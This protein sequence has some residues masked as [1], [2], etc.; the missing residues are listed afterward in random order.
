MADLGQ[1]RADFEQI[2]AD[3][4]QGWGL[5]QRSRFDK[6]WADVETKW[7]EF[8]RVGADVGRRSN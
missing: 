4:G 7:P 1:M 5:V 3:V 6:S 2:W 8:G